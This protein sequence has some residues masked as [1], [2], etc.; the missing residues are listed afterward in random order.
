MATDASEQQALP[1]GKVHLEGE[2]LG[3]APATVDRGPGPDETR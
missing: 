2:N 3:S 1:E